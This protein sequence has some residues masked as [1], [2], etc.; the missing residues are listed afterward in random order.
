VKRSRD[1]FVALE[2][3]IYRMLLTRGMKGCYISSQNADTRD[4]L[5]SRMSSDLEEGEDSPLLVGQVE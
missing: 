4:F 5:A 2:K 1:Q 3:N